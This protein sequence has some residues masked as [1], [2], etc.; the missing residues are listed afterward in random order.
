[1]S[2]VG[3][4]GWEGKRCNMLF[5][6]SVGCAQ[7]INRSVGSMLRPALQ[8]LLLQDDPASVLMAT[9]TLWPGAELETCSSSSWSDNRSAWARCC[10]KA[11]I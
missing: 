5:F 3:S 7:D 6:G 2:M 10:P 4:G 9:A 11:G 8:G 1:M